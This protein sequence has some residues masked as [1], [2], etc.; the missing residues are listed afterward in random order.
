[1]QRKKSSTFSP[2]HP[3]P[4]TDFFSFLWEKLFSFLLIQQAVTCGKSK[5]R[6]STRA[7]RKSAS[8]VTTSEC[9]FVLQRLRPV[10]ELLRLLLLHLLGGSLC[11]LGGKEEKDDAASCGLYVKWRRGKKKSGLRF[12]LLIFSWGS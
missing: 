4:F 1:M 11:L 12:S 6:C 5:L 2:F 10:S 7:S 9:V 8:Y 3:V